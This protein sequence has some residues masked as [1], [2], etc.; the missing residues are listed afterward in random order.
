MY[1][2]M[3]SSSS[4]RST[5][6][7]AT[8][9]TQHHSIAIAD[10]HQKEHQQQNNIYKKKNIRPTHPIIASRIVTTAQSRL[11]SY[12]CFIPLVV[13]QTY[14]HLL[15]IRSPLSLSSLADGSLS[16]FLSLCI[17]SIE[18]YC[19]NVPLFSLFSYRHPPSTSEK[20]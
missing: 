16:L 14:A 8:N 9:Y 15:S 11:K 5:F 20:H 4:S 1:M 6:P 2:M 12:K 13:H 19:N 10:H 18:I 7:P 17:L 3:S